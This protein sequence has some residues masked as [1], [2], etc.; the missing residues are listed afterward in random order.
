MGTKTILVM[1]HAEKSDDPL[2]PLLTDAGRLRAQRLVDYIPKTFGREPKFLIASAVS[3][4][5]Q[6][7]IETLEPIATHDGLHIDSSYADQD[8]GAFAHH[9]RPRIFSSP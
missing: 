5:S 8:Y 2:D 9:L 3:K 7:P 1:R 4:H 6:R